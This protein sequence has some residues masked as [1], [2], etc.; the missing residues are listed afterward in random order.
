MK[1][2][3]CIFF[4]AL[5]VCS[6]EEVVSID[7]HETSMRI[8]IEG[9]VT[10]VTDNNFVKVSRTLPFYQDGV[11]PKIV[12][13]VVTVT[14][15]LGN[16]YNFS[17]NPSGKV[18]TEGCYLPSTSFV[19]VVGREYT[20][21]VLVN[22][23]TYSAKEKLLDVTSV[24]SMNYKINEREQDKFKVPKQSDRIYEVDIW[25]KEPKET[26]DFYLFK[27]YRN[28]SLK[29]DSPTSV[30]FI[31]D[32]LLGEKIDGLASP[33]Y[34]SLNDTARFEIYSLSRNAYLFYSDF[35]NSLNSDGGML[36]SP[37]SNPRTNL[38]NGALG[39]FQV[40]ALSSMELI[41]K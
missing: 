16:I 37:P 5:A 24:E 11:T 22:G 25:A 19:G 8:V 18:E 23:I 4:L 10:N 40:S 29:Y 14:D 2:L 17:H 31:D 36:D 9:L 28:D 20:L 34:Y 33:I 27:F 32:D 35:A 30:Y 7:V 12:D 6:C 3:T 39:L 13:A 26:K 21:S 38:S 1:I 15:N 41:L